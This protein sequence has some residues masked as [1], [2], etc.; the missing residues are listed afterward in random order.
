MRTLLKRA[1]LVLVVAFAVGWVVGCE[2]GRPTSAPSA[3]ASGEVT[4]KCTGCAKTENVA[5][6]ATA[7]SC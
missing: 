2:N 6:S 4:Y 3:P 5:S 7:P 1:A